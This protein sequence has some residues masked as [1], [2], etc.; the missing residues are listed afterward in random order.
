MKIGVMGG[1]GFNNAGDEAQLMATI[2]SLKAI[3]VDDLVVFTPDEDF[4]SKYHNVKTFLAS[5]V[6]IFFEGRLPFYNARFPYK[7]FLFKEWVKFLLVI[8]LFVLGVCFLANTWLSKNFKFCVF[9]R[10]FIKQLESLDYLHFSG[11]G[12]FTKDTFSRLI[13]FCFIM[14]AC[15]ILGVTV[16]M[17]GQTLGLWDAPILKKF[18]GFSVKG[19]K[20]ISLR[21]VDKSCNYLKDLDVPCCVTEICDDAYGVDVKSIRC[22]NYIILHFHL[23]GKS[24][25]IKYKKMI[26]DFYSKILSVMNSKNYRSVLVSM[27]PTD[28]KAM[29]EFSKKY[30]VEISS[31]D[32]SFARKMDLYAGCNGVITMKHHPIIFG[33]LFNK[34]VVSFYDSPYY[35]QKNDGAFNSMSIPVSNFEIT[36]FDF[37]VG[38]FDFPYEFK[39]EW[40]VQIANK[41]N[42]RKKWFEAVYE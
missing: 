4:T 29:N 28:D 38:L 13:D 32:D 23:W 39:A 16:N 40:G 31:S 5:R 22:E 42:E 24:R 41:V 15:R 36:D 6:A 7:T 10:K 25:D 21:D 17:S 14:I 33:F 8:P 27:T 3:G 12:Y 37:N 26:F 9:N 19:I 2:K 11:G 20:N 1:Y 35:K 18:V 30:N 34:P